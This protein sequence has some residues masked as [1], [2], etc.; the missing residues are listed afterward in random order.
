MQRQSCLP[1][2]INCVK[3]GVGDFEILAEMKHRNIELALRN[4]SLI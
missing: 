4:V 1:L 2:N 3:T